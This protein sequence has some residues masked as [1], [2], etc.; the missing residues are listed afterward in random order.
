MDILNSA[1][2]PDHIFQLPEGFIIPEK[3]PKR[4]AGA[5]DFSVL[6]EE[7]MAAAEKV[8]KFV[9][10]PL[11]EGML[12]I[13][14]YAGTGKTF[15]TTRLSEWM[16]YAQKLSL[17]VTAPTN[18]AVQVIRDMS[19]FEHDHLKHQTIHSLLG[20]KMTYDNYGRMRF[21]PSTQDLPDLESKDVLIIDETSMLNKELYDMVREYPLKGVKII[22][23]GDPAQIPPVKEI[24]SMPFLSKIR[25]RDKI[26]LNRLT[27]IM[28]QAAD[29]P[30]L[31]YA[32]AIR[33]QRL[34]QTFG[35]EHETRLHEGTGICFISKKDKETIYRL[36]DLYFCNDI[37]RQYPDFM[38][39]VT[40]RNITANAVNVKVRRM[41]YRDVIAEDE[42]MPKI[43]QGEKL[44]ADEPII[45]GQRF[46]ANTNQELEVLSY[47]IKQ[48][49]VRSFIQQREMVNDFFKYY[50]TVV[51]I[52]G[53]SSPKKEVIRIIHEDSEINLHT[54]L[55]GIKLYTLKLPNGYLRSEGW[56]RYY[57]LKNTFAAI[58]YNYA[59]TAHKAQGS[60]YENCM[61][62]EW[63]MTENPNYLEANRIKYVAATRARKLLFIIR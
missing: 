57:E 46:I 11:A 42:V 53:D 54:A 12:S 14:G 19:D 21:T 47:T 61:M 52:Y 48:T 4:K 33:E 40:W 34:K 1:G 39:V 62:L 51:M 56:A 36:C 22:F 50:E 63:D 17:A 60:T 16:V 9:T 25:T 27:N 49:H 8:M 13:E 15:L 18:K 2:L 5:V 6:S 26:Q 37:F 3:R 38:K 23:I 44:I 20:L 32:T 7:Q 29:N 58:K 28:R 35:Y 45:E 59:I 10:N 43:M 41:L 31:H 55:E 24:E 30:I